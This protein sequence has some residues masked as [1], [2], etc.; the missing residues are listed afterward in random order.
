MMVAA[1]NVGGQRSKMIR[2]C[3][4]RIGFL[5]SNN[6]RAMRAIV[7]A[8]EADALGATAALVVSNRKESS[9]L[10]FAD[11]HQI[12]AL[13]IPTLPDEELADERLC[14]SLST[15]NV[16]I[17]VLSGYL[18]Q[19][20][21]KT[22]RAFHGCVLSTHPALLPKFGGKGMYGRRVHEAVLA[23]REQTTGAT[24]HLVD[25]DYDHGR[26]LAQREVAIEESDDPDSL[27]RKVMQV[28]G[29]LFVEVLRRVASGDL[30][31]GGMMRESG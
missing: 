27:M 28:E 25:A 7:A 16:Q 15:A 4:M 19:L 26:V 14:G 23:A 8:I 21:P 24:I 13:C 10:A 18:R 31:L 11:Q 2:C 9:A 6:G 17:I 12:P 3:V 5:A 29:T 30:R 22:L 20:G 1:L